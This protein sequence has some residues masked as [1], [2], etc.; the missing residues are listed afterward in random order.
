M[1]APS[2]PSRSALAAIAAGSLAL[3]AACGGDT[4]P[5]TRDAGGDAPSASRTTATRPSRSRPLGAEDPGHEGPLR[6]RHRTTARSKGYEVLVQDPNLDPQ[7]QVTDLPERRS[8]PGR[9][10]GAWAI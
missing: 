2:K 10:A 8:S 6:G 7:K 1:Y 4:Q 5:Q 3:L 9:V